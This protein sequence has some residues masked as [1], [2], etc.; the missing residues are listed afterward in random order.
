MI[1]TGLSGVRSRKLVGNFWGARSWDR[2][3]VPFPIGSRESED[4]IFSPMMYLLCAKFFSLDWSDYRGRFCTW[5]DRYMS[6]TLSANRMTGSTPFCAF[7]AIAIHLSHC[8]CIFAGLSIWLEHGVALSVLSQGRVCTFW[9]ASNLWAG[10]CKR[11][12]KH[13]VDSVC[14]RRRKVKHIRNSHVRRH[15]PA[16]SRLG[17]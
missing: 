6:S 17:Q 10:G 3:T 8:T 9:I 13:A 16:S 15:R 14:W 12:W 11:R 4:Q 1:L 2:W 7:S 5:R